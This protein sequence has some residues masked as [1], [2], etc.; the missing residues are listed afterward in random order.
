MAPSRKGEAICDSLF[1]TVGVFVPVVVSLY[2]Y[3]HEPKSLFRILFIIFV[4]F[5]GFVM[6]RHIWAQL[7]NKVVG[8]FRKNE[9]T[10]GERTHFYKTYQPSVVLLCSD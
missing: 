5:V 3:R 1:M 4:L 2:L 9:E 8:Y 7:A 6:S 10:E